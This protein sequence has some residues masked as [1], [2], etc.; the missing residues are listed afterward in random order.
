MS[1]HTGSILLKIVRFN[2]AV[3]NADAV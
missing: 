2:R 3:W 1:L